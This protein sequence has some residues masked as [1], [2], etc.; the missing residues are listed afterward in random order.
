[1]HFRYPKDSEFSS[2][3]GLSLEWLETNGLGGYASST[4]TNCH[5]RKYHGLLVSALDSLP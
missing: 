4:I 1:M 5:T 3:K 2:E